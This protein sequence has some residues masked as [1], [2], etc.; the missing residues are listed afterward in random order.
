VAPQS[1]IGV[2]VEKSCKRNLV[3]LWA[4]RRL[5]VDFGPLIMWVGKRGVRCGLP[6]I[7]PGPRNLENLVP[8]LFGE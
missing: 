6:V 8:V 2:V 1:Q 7:R 5:L 3:G 4:Y